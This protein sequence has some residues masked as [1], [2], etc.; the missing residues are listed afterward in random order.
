MNKRILKRT[1]SILVSALRWV[2]L[3]AVGYIALYP[4]FV[5][6]SNSLMTMEDVLDQS[7]VYIPKTVTLDNF[8]TALDKLNF[9]T[10]LKSTLLIPVLSGMIEVV[11][12]AVTAYGF[13]RFKFREN[14]I[15][16][17][18]VIATIAVPST[19][20]MIPQYTAFYNFDPLKLLAVIN[21]ISGKSL[22][23]NLLNTGFTMWLPSIFSVGLRSG[24]FIFIYRQFFK[25]LPRE[26]EEAAYV[27]GANPF[28]AFI[29]VIIPSST[30]AII[31][32]TVFSLVWHWNEYYITN[33]FLLED[34]RPLSV[35]LKIIAGD[36]KLVNGVRMAGALVFIA[37]VLVIYLVLQRRFIKSIDKVGIV[38]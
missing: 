24:V 3:I 17:G 33:M 1:G 12:C 22:Q 35:M 20:L 10:A 16:F 19:L 38:G 15:L 27:D 21:K 28:T 11:T 2:F 37:P 23:I 5:M 30:V 36:T 34:N 13:A 14:N 29:R 6:I 8:K 18:L 31:T 25:G 9:L 32:V 7:V 26:F 4:L